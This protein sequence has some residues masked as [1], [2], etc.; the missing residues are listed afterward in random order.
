MQLHRNYNVEDLALI[1]VESRENSLIRIK[2]LQ[3]EIFKGLI[4]ACAIDDYDI[5]G[6]RINN[7]APSSY[8]FY[9]Q[10][11]KDFNKLYTGTIETYIFTKLKVKRTLVGRGYSLVNGKIS[12][13]IYNNKKLIIGSIT[14]LLAVLYLSK[15]AREGIRSFLEI[16]SS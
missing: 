15:K 2:A 14:G 11:K 13:T 3:K 16:E 9:R 8:E 1:P 7:L 10:L 6:T 4:I 5:L 12:N